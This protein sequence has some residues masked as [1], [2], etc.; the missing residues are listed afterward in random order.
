MGFH[1]S[2]DIL[3]NVYLLV[4]F[5]GAFPAWAS[6]NHKPRCMCNILCKQQYATGQ[7]PL[8]LPSSKRIRARL[9]WCC[10][11]VPDSTQKVMVFRLQS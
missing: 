2:V 5:E 11:E 4:L 9:A 1:L 7:R 6:Q 8:F 10:A 3:C